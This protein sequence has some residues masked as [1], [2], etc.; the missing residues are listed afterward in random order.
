MHFRHL[1][2]ANK[3]KNFDFVVT[4]G[5]EV[6]DISNL[7]SHGNDEIKIINVALFYPLQTV[8]M[9]I[10]LCLNILIFETLLLGDTALKVCS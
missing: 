3:V 1:K 9:T 4:M 6:R 8:C 7:V 5:Y 2:G 10:Q